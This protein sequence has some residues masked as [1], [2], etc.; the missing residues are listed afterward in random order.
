LIQEIAL[1]L[2]AA[3]VAV[4]LAKRLR[5]GAVLG[6]LL[7][8]IAIGP[9]GFG[10]ISRVE[11]VLHASE[12]GVV[13]LMFIIGLE[14]QPSRLWRLRRE[15]FGMGGAQVLVTTVV[16][17]AIAAALGQ[18]ASAATVAGFGLAMSSTAFVLQ[19]LAE[20]NELASRHGRAA[21]AIL[22]FQD[23]AV[24]PFLAILPMLAGDNAFESSEAWRGA[25][26]LAAIFIAV[27]GLGRYA[28]RP[29]FR[30][31]AI[32]N[33]PEVFTAASLL[34]VIG[35]ALAMQAAGMSMSFGAFL[36]GVLLADSEYRHELQADIEPFKGLLLGLFFIAVG[37]SANVGL[38]VT[39]PLAVLGLVLA[40]IA[41]K[42]IVLYVVGRI[43]DLP[44]DSSRALAIAASQGGEFAFVLFSAAVA[45]RVM[46][47]ALADLLVVAVTASMML[48][49]PLYALQ[50]RIRGKAAPVRPYDQL[51]GTEN[52]VIIAGFGP[53]G[54]IVARAMRVRKIGFT[55]LE[56][57]P[58]QVDF[59]RRFGNKIFYGDAGRLDLLKAARADKAR[60][61]VLTIPKL[62]PSIQIAETVR[63]HFPN[64]TIWAV[65]VDRNH[66]MHLMDLGI[67]HVIRR[68][69]FSSLEMTRRLL[70]DFGDSEARAAE[71]I[72]KFRAHDEK[73]L[74]KQQAVFRDE[75]KL[76]QTS[77]ESVREL[78]QLFE[79]DREVPAEP[80][81]AAASPESA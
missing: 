74:L 60:A 5:L 19:M 80:P 71:S 12:F 8:G 51:D 77:Q 1:F 72:R 21:F 40:L 7:A 16:L 70:I 64:L 65:A 76:I 17:A 79:S 30:A 78:E 14:L 34:T 63:K 22:L 48:T 53:F 55:V 29:V 26:K 44:N 81:P 42:A 47:Q 69:Y 38:V 73:T 18:K 37:M 9:W 52:P 56:K 27:I 75:Q 61:F 45:A 66:A 49:P 6:Y 11:D 41:I 31:L 33:T 39:K 57:N 68:S 46:P 35:F 67:Q 36:A 2:A 20:K 4:P 23:I 50:A 54:Q 59:V 28:L 25:L 10:W 32:T 58:E 15:V 43:F 24:I 3:V 13:L 62:E